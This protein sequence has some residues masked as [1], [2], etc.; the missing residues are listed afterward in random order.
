MFT[1]IQTK[2]K[3]YTAKH[4]INCISNIAPRSGNSTSLSQDVQEKRDVAMKLLSQYIKQ[5]RWELFNTFAAYKI[6]CNGWGEFTYV[7][8]QEGEKTQ[9]KT[10]FSKMIRDEKNGCTMKTI[11]L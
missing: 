10:I 5:N 9:A 4:V 3:E 7:E 11:G 2:E 8:T 6:V 1:V